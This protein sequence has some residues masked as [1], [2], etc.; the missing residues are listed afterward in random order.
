M[1]FISWIKG[2]FDKTIKGSKSGKELV[3]LATKSSIK[4]GA[5]IEVKPGY[6]GVV[7]A[8]GQVCDV[9]AEGRHRLEPKELPLA[10]R[11]LKLTT[12]NK[13]GDLPTKF[14]ADIYFVNLGKFENEFL[15][16]YFVKA[17]GDGYKNVK[18]RL[19]GRY[20]YSVIN[21]IDFLDAMLTQFGKIADDLAKM[22]ISDWI[23]L[24]CVKA[25]QKNKPTIAE[26]LLDKSRPFDGVNEYINKELY[27]CGLR[28][29]EIEVLN[30]EFPKKIKKQIS[31][32]YFLETENPNNTIKQ[33]SERQ[34]EHNSEKVY[35]AESKSIEQDMS[36]INYTFNSDGNS[37]V[38]VGMT[39]LTL[40]NE[41]NLV[42][43]QVEI[44]KSD[45]AF[46]NE[47][48]LNVDQ[49]IEK[50]IS[51][52]KCPHC[53]ALNST[54]AKICFSCGKKIDGI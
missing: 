28:L 15:S 10:S 34:F 18:V 48:F 37:Q 8:K 43:K 5:D 40:N 20:V 46:G 39:P 42:E 3:F 26:L 27:D 52:K 14:K 49:P 11:K 13:K 53:K 17:N 6:A 51:Y 2:W 23:G 38:D 41:I 22:E 9:F 50:T 36:N 54:E 44:N 30:K 16:R 1:G 31:L 21:P 24:L 4:I 35:S 45:Y 33:A 7:V 12:Q 29:E 25:V 32:K 19:C 47:N